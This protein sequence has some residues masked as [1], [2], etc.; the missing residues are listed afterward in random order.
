ML[1]VKDWSRIATGMAIRLLPTVGRE[2]AELGLLSPVVSRRGWEL[3]EG[4]QDCIPADRHV[5]KPA[6]AVKGTEL[7]NEHKNTPAAE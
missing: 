5:S 1:A 2:F 4:E 6:I 7:I 3:Q